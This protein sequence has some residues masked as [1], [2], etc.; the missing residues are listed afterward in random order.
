M[1]DGG[2]GDLVIVKNL[3]RYE[4]N[5]SSINAFLLIFDRKIRIFEQL[6]DLL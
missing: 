5:T 6:P 2:K 3:F 1:V 4:I